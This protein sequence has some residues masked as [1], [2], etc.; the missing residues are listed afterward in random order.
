VF[1]TDIRL[2]PF[3]SIT[4]TPQ[5]W[6]TNLLSQATDE[7]RQATLDTVWQTQDNDESA[8]PYLMPKTLPLSLFTGTEVISLK[9]PVAMVAD[10]LLMQMAMFSTK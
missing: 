6:Q 3:K 7:G 9:A 2:H 1:H 10:W 5:D 4:V 8:E